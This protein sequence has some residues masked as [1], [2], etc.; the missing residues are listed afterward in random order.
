MQSEKAKPKVQKILGIILSVLTY[1]FFGICVLSLIL[2]V[3]SKKDHDGAV[4][5]FSH[6][7]RIVLSDSMAKC[8]KTDVSEYEIKDI[9]VKSMLFIEL[10]PEDEQEAEAWYSEL[11][12][13][14]VLTFRYLYV[15]QETITHR[16]TS[17]EETKDGYIIKLEGDNKSSDS[18]TLTQTI[19]TASVDSPNYIIGK[20]VGQSYPLGLLVTALKSP[21]G[22]LTVV[23]IPCVIIAIFEIIKLVGIFSEGKRKRAQS[24]IDKRDAELEEMKR[25]LEEL[26]QMA[27][28]GQN[29]AEVN[30]EQG[31]EQK[32]SI[33]EAQITEDEQAKDTEAK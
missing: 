26:K 21:V 22:I 2:S 3:S 8:D 6:Q 12:V 25:Q 13:G 30:P 20:V 1:L 4:S 7:A 28:K 15:T 27:M 19:N 33:Q 17:I 16:I 31:K 23:I 5:I 9:S 11:K 32:E 10:V 18:N 24:E 29:P 14:D